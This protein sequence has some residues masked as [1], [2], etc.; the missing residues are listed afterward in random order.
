MQKWRMGTAVLTAAFLAVSGAGLVRAEGKLAL[1]TKSMN[2][3]YFL[4][5]AEGFEEAA[6][7]AGAECIVSHPLYAYADEQIPILDSLLSQEVDAIAIAANDASRLGEALEQAR[8]AGIF[9]VTVDSDTVPEQR[10][11]F[12]SQTGAQ[13]VGRTMLEAVKQEGGGR[14]AILSTTVDAPNQNA[15]IEVMKTLSQ[16]EAYADLELVE[17]VYGEDEAEASAEAVRRL[18]EEEPDL[19]VICSLTSAGTTACLKTLEEEESSVRFTGL[20]MPSEVAA[21]LEKENPNTQAVYLWNPADLGRMAACACLGLMEGTITGAEGEVLEVPG[22]A[23]SSAEL[24][25]G[26]GGGCEVV[27]GDLQSFTPE[28]IGEWKN[29]F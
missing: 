16:E 13:T 4:A 6:G 3:P 2:N 20:G 1:V 5:L 21:Y 7:E 8:E 10:T 26:E 11:L 25:L 12:V 18:L 22:L 14:Y 29:V 9:V 19:S 28:N 23:D 24:T 27:L 17:V 15:W